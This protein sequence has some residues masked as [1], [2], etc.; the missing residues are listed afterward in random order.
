M[1]AEAAIT[2]GFVGLGNLGIP[3]WHIAPVNA[4]LGN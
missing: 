3:T 1:T 2:V 4:P